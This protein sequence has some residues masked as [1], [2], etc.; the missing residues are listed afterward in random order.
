MKNAIIK[1]QSILLF[2]VCSFV[3][4]GCLKEQKKPE[5]IKKIEDVSEKG[6]ELSTRAVNDSTFTSSEEYKTE[7]DR[8]NA[9]LMRK[10]S[11]MD[12]NDKLLVYFES[13]L[14]MLKKYTD[15]EKQN[16]ALTQNK[17]YMQITMQW[18]SK[19]QEYNQAL[20][21]LKLNENQKKKFDELNANF[22][23]L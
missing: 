17:K 2:I 21:R 6:E 14:R 15:K 23:T 10:T 13:S 16:R 3:F 12:E 9:A 1:R 11:T 7:M 22:S 8:F 20:K 18:G 19:V 4:S 5:Q